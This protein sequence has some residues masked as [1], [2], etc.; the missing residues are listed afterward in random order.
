M[1]NNDLNLNFCGA[2]EVTV[3]EMSYIRMIVKYAYFKNMQFIILIIAESV[4]EKGNKVIELSVEQSN[5][6]IYDFSIET[7][8]TILCCRLGVVNVLTFAAY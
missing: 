4:Y 7:E 1:N 6:K 8:S 5:S 3:F 2:F